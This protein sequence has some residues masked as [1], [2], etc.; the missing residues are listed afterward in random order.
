MT[1][2][3][4]EGITTGALPA[5]LPHRIQQN[6]QNNAKQDRCRERKIN[7]RILPAV[8]DV[9]R[10]PPDRKVR[11]SQKSHHDSNQNKRPAQKYEKL[12]KVRHRTQCLENPRLFS[13]VAKIAR[14]GADRLDVLPSLSIRHN[15]GRLH[16]TAVS[17][18]RCFD[19]STA[20]SF[21]LRRSS[22]VA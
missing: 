1:P 13:I 14:R 21:S 12:P 15:S 22:H 2:G 19:Q 6:R 16:R 3:R 11:L 18:G 9:S 8:H 20:T 10:Q 17:Y 7:R 4:R 5:P